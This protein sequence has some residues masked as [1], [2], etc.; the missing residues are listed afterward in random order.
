[1]QKWISD[2]PQ[3]LERCV[4]VDPVIKLQKGAI[5]IINKVSYLE[6]ANKLSSIRKTVNT[7]WLW[8]YS[9]WVK[10]RSHTLT[11]CST[12][13]HCCHPRKEIGL[14]FTFVIVSCCNVLLSRNNVIFSCFYVII[15]TLQRDTEPGLTPRVAAIR[16]RNVA[17]RQSLKK[18]KK[19]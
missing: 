14:S 2:P 7:V 15:L 5:R 3:T 8:V 6:T 1:M 17:L 4:Y 9:V 10:N 11:L 16:F 12:E 19:G 18:K 13:V